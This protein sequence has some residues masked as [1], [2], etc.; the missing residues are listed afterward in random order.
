MLFDH[1]CDTTSTW[2]IGLM[3]ANCLQIGNSYLMFFGLLWMAF[4][5]FFFA[6]W[7]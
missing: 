7:S 4:L 1:G 5:G 2:V 6:M 3:V